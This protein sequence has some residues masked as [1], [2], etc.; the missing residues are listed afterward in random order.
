M[1]GYLFLDLGAPHIT[2]IPTAGAAEVFPALARAL[3]PPAQSARDPLH[4][5]PPTPK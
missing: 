3:L 2:P 5:R 1:H 4:P